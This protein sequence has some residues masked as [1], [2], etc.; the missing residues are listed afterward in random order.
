MFQNCIRC[1]ICVENCS[2]FGVNPLFPVRNRRART[3]SAFGS[4][5]NVPWMTGSSTAAS[6]SDVR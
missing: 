4:T 1:T 2:V 5:V 3:P 6:A